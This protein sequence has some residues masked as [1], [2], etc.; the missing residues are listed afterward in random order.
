MSVLTPQVV[1]YCA[2]ECSWQHSGE[3]SVADMVDA[4]RY[5]HRH[6]HKPVTL[7]DVL[8]LGRLVEPRKNAQGL[9]KVGV[10]VGWDVK[11]HSEQVPAALDKLIAVQP[12]IGD[13]TEVEVTEWFRQ[14]EEIH[15]FRDGNGRTGTLF[16]NWLRN[17]LHEP[18][19]VPNLWNDPQREAARV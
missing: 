2:E 3:V 18:V 6:R 12:T 19:H 16:Y 17:S 14:Y 9:R 5:A 4:W 15:P 13:A 8:A 11:M 7:R 10:R 1:R